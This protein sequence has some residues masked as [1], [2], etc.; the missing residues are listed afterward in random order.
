M[1]SH[2]LSPALLSSR[3]S[4]RVRP[5]RPA[6]AAATIVVFRDAVAHLAA[7]DYSAEQIKA[8]A[9]RTGTIERWNARRTAAHTWVA[10]DRGAADGHLRRWD[11]DGDCDGDCTDSGAVVGFIDVDDSGY[12]DMLFVAPHCARQGVATALLGAVER[13]AA[14]RGTG[15]DAGRGIRRNAEDGDGEGIG[16]LRVHASITA[17]P[18]FERYGFRVVAIRH[19]HIGRVAFVNYLMVRGYGRR[20]ITVINGL[21]K[22]I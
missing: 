4:C 21:L 11:C 7:A 17:R 19:P 2:A 16:E 12:I 10:V 1:A 8:W 22:E 13:F 20:Q 3:G 15:Y 5:Y 9:G 18:F 14:A 6:D